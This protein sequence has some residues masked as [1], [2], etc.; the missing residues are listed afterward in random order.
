MLEVLN[1]GNT[2][3]TRRMQNQK[4]ILP[5]KVSGVWPGKCEGGKRLGAKEWELREWELREWELREW[6]LREWEVGHTCG[7]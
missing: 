5:F 1:N 6:E 3:L 7:W 4:N 2:I